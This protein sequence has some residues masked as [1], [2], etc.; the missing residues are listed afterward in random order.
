MNEVN[1][2]KLGLFNLLGPATFRFAMFMANGSQEGLAFRILLDN[3]DQLDL[4][5]QIVQ[6]ELIPTLQTAG[7]LLQDDVDRIQQY[8]NSSLGL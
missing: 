2:D 4:T 8:I 5:S 7:V 6:Q 1:I 3:V